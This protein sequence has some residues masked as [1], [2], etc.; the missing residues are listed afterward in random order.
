MI[1]AILYF[2]ISIFFFIQINSCGPASPDSE[3]KNTRIILVNPSA[4]YIESLVYLAK[5][6]I[7]NIPNLAF[8]AVF[9]NNVQHRFKES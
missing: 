7:I 5:N 9:Y 8:Q 6:K 3:S 1:R 2:F 4:W